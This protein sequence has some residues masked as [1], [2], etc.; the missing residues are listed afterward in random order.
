M[1]D[2]R[3][4]K[5]LEDM[6]GTIDFD[7]GMSRDLGEPISPEMK[8]QEYLYNEIIKLQQENESLKLINKQHK[9]I[10]G[11]LQKENK[12]LFDTKY[13]L[14]EFEKEIKHEYDLIDKTF[15]KI[16]FTKGYLEALDLCLIKLQRLKK[17]LN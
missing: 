8:D 1:S 15:K 7:K 11:N 12:E 2:K 14:N 13:I 16:P 10:N 6:K 3:L 4:Q 9:E 17:D 5:I